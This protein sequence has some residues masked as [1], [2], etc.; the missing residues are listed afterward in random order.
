MGDNVKHTLNI[1]N[2]LTSFLVLA[3]INMIGKIKGGGE[4][5]EKIQS[6][7]RKSKNVLVTHLAGKDFLKILLHYSTNV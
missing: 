4:K 1:K 7:W 3:R 6:L 2:V 5:R